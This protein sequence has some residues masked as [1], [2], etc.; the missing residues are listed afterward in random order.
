MPR[1]TDYSF[2]FQ[3]MFGTSRMNLVNNIQL[4]N[5]I[6]VIYTKLIVNILNGLKNYLKT[7][8]LFIKR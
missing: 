8:L 1:I 3:S 6:Q 4:R 7:K 5:L 2:L